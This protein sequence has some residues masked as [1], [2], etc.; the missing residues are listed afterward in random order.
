MLSVVTKGGAFSSDVE[1]FED[2]QT[3]IRRNVRRHFSVLDEA[4]DD[5][6]SRIRIP[7]WQSPLS[8]LSTYS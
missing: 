2:P 5:M 4:S 7:M 3:L 6:I 8:V 1:Q